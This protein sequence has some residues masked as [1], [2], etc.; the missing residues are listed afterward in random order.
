MA[1]T[2]DTGTFETAAASALS[3][4]KPW[5]GLERR[6]GTLEVFAVRL[7]AIHN[8]LNDL[9]AVTRD[10]VKAI[11]KL[12]LVEDRQKQ[13]RQSMDAVR[14]DIESLG[15]RVVALEIKSPGVA[16]VASW[17]DRAVLAVVGLVLLMVAKHVG[18]FG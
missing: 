13:D 3:H 14:K 16:R 12:A 4:D 15:R 8:D 1:D 17:I 10:L 6:G 7:E 9:R 11:S 2:D 18:V 5:D